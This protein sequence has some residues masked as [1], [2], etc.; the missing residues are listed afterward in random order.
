M[1][2]KFNSSIIKKK[3]DFF[4]NIAE[5]PEVA[6]VEGDI[7][8]TVGV[9]ASS[10]SCFCSFSYFGISSKLGSL[11]FG[12]PFPTIERN[13]GSTMVAWNILATLTYVDFIII[14][15]QLV[16]ELK[17]PIEFILGYN[18]WCHKVL[19]FFT[20]DFPYLILKRN[21]QKHCWANRFKLKLVML[22]FF[23]LGW[24]I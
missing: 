5:Q 3:S 2:K 4:E 16:G 22:A 1:R 8:A 13:N 7:V 10:S 21:S 11:S 12:C 24:L 15:F 14:I 6:D 17:A 20:R 19:E 9:G 18:L 23:Q